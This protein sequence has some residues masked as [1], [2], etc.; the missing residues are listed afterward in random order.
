MKKWDIKITKDEWDELWFDY[1]YYGTS[2]DIEYTITYKYEVLTVCF[3]F[4]IQRVK[5][6]FSTHLIKIIQKILSILAK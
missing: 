6:L 5:N 3:I 2:D 4:Q 1:D